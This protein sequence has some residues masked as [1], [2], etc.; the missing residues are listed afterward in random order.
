MKT[1]KTQFHIGG[2]L[3]VGAIAVVLFYPARTTA[4][5]TATNPATTTVLVTD[6]MS[7]QNP[8]RVTVSSSQNLLAFKQIRVVFQS[9][10]G[11]CSAALLEYDSNSVPIGTLGTFGGSNQD[12]SFTKTF[13]T[14]GAQVAIQFVN[15]AATVDTFRFVVYGQPYESSTTR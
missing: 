6:T 7:M 8:A 1:Q 9:G 5:A 3:V 14:P 10:L 15:N 4:T 2:L 12:C 11:N 13:D